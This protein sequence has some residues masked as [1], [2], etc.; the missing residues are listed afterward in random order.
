MTLTLDV[1]DATADQRRD[2]IQA[3]R[4]ALALL[5]WIERLDSPPRTAAPQET[6]GGAVSLEAALLLA[7]APVAL[8]HL[9]A[10]LRDWA[11]RPGRSPVTFVLEQ[12]D[13]EICFRYDPKT[14]TADNAQ[15]W[16][17][18]VLAASEAEER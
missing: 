12:R 17:A 18:R 15:R 2:A 14:M 13:G 5:P 1:A 10:A 8:N 6:R 3:L 16:L 9:L 4:R 11:A 7:L